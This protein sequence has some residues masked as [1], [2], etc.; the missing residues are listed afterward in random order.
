MNAFDPAALDCL[1]ALADAGSFERAA[2][3]LAITR[4]C[5][6]A[7]ARWKPISA[8]CWWCDRARCA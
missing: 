8:G 7:C 4:P 2:Q 3:K 5:R 1:A 6:N